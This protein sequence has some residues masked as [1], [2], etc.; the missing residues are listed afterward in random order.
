MV[1]TGA[2]LRATVPV[3]KD[4]IMRDATPDKGAYEYANVDHIPPS[5]PTNLRVL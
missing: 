3:D 5:A 2:D 4:G 1:N